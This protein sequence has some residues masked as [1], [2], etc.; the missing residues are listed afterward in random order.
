VITNYALA[1]L[2][3]VLNASAFVCVALGAWAIQRRRIETHKRFMLSAFTISI[4]FL[5]SYLTR[6]W[7]FGD[8]HF[9]GAGF[10]R[11]AYFA[12]LISHVGLALLIAPAVVYTVALGLRDQRA[13]HKRIAR[14]VLPVW[15]YVLATGVLVYLWLYQF[16]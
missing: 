8:M 13:R 7:L 9:R 2:N 5:A 6:M 4:F 12:L 15:L 14:K 1:T 10:A 11:Y 3:A 16:S